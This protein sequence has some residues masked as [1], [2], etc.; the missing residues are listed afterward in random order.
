MPT[1][2]LILCE[3]TS[4]WAV[5]FRRALHNTPAA[6]LETRSLAQCGRELADSPHSV[7]GLEVTASNLDAVL[8]SLGQW[9][10]LRPR[11]RA[12][13]LA[14]ASLTAAEPLLREMGA[15]AVLYS[16]RESS[17]VT[18]LIVRHLALAPKEEL[19]LREA[20]LQRLP[21]AGAATTSSA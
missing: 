21:W 4:R 15:Q 17:S 12:L 5:A 20:I 1:P 18:G 8:E 7:L 3:K 2:R 10:P 16:P 9:L 11:A 6:I 19:P 14:D 13:A